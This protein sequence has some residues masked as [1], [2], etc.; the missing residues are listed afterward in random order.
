[1]TKFARFTL[2]TMLLGSLALPAVA[3][4]GATSSVPM[5]PTAKVLPGVHHRTAGH[6]N[7]VRRAAD[8]VRTPTVTSGNSSA[9]PAPVASKNV[10]ADGKT[11]M[12]SSVGVH[13]KD[14]MI[15]SK[16]AATPVAPAPAPS[17][18]PHASGAATT[19]P[20]LPHV[21]Q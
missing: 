16:A 2:T 6:S 9:L 12:G 5:Q 3:Q 4:S 10:A 20:G 17:T 15:E 11:V 19:N 8:V 7:H 13:G 21:R 18:T 1:M 14:A